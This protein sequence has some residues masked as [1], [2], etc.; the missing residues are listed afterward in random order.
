M[1]S[2][3]RYPRTARLNEAILEVLADEVERC[4]DPRLE[5]VTITGVDV[6]RDLAYATVYFSTLGAETTASGGSRRADA[7]AGLRAA[8]SHLRAALGRQLR[9]RQVPE[10]EFRVD[11]GILAGQRI[12]EILRGEAPAPEDDEEEGP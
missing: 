1:T 9:I 8:A 10:L 6:T 12:D 7:G 5:L 11:H 4:S 3:R 2:S